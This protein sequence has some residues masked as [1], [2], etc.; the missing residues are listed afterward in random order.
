MRIAVIHLNLLCFLLVDP[1]AQQ[2]SIQW[3][4]QMLL[5]SY[6]LVLGS[7]K[8]EDCLLGLGLAHLFVPRNGLVVQ[9]LTAG[10]HLLSAQFLVSHHSLVKFHLGQKVLEDSILLDRIPFVAL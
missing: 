7:S 2:A 8:V 6:H 3:G 4:S 1:I 10:P 5:H 9:Q